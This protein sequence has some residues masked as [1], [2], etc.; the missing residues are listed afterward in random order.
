MKKKD[1]LNYSITKMLY[2]NA[3]K[4]IVSFI[5]WHKR[6]RF[7]TH[8]VEG[9]KNLLKK[10]SNSSYMNLK[11]TE[12]ALESLQTYQKLAVVSALASYCSELHDQQSSVSNKSW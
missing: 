2:R 12:A 3:K 4:T 8:K 11:I 10:K 7:K 1:M 5:Y 6:K 9:Q